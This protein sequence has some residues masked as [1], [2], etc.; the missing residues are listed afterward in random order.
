MP[1]NPFAEGLVKKPSAVDGRSSFQKMWDRIKGVMTDTSLTNPA[2][3]NPGI[4]NSFQEQLG[5]KTQAGSSGNKF[6]IRD[7]VNSVLSTTV[8]GYSQALDQIKDY[9]SS[10]GKGE[11]GII[12]GGNFKFRSPKKGTGITSAPAGFRNKK[13]AAQPVRDRSSYYGSKKYAGTLSSG[14]KF[15][16]NPWTGFRRGGKSSGLRGTPLV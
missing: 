14:Q 12:D 6:G 10:D 16:H 8:P 7:L 13:S 11:L 9:Y 4:V 3:N 15:Y 5:E 1:I 2:E